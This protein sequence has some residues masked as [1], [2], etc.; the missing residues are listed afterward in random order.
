MCD[1]VTSLVSDLR[2][3]TGAGAGGGEQ[4]SLLVSAGA[5]YDNSG[6]QVDDEGHVIKPGSS[7]SKGSRQELYGD[8]TS[9]SA[10]TDAEHDVSAQRVTSATTD[11]EHEV[12]T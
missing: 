12:G 10:T 3:G 8:N 9:V 1:V 7:S 6:F 11:A 4:R 5:N 2:A